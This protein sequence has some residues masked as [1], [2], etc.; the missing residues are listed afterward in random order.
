MSRDLTICVVDGA[1]ISDMERVG[2]YPRATTTASDVVDRPGIF[3]APLSDSF[4]LLGTDPDLVTVGEALAAHLGT[5]V[6]TAVLQ[7]STDTYLF[8]VEGGP[9]A[10]LSDVEFADDGGGEQI[11]DYSSYSQPSWHGMRTL[12]TVAGDVASD[13]GEPLPEE[14]AI[15]NLD[16]E[17]TVEL[18]RRVTGI[19]LAD[20]DPLPVT[21]LAALASPDGEDITEQESLDV[22]EE[23]DPASQ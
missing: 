16:E 20:L 12:M 13:H 19:V 10:P 22:S 7:R 18:L 3:G 11:A 23:A 21:H 2:L 15:T 6:V 5:R 17:G 9:S 4:L 8:Q 1:E 14:D